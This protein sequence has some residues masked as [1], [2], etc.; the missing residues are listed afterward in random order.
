[1]YS[2]LLLQVASQLKASADPCDAPFLPEQPPTPLPPLPPPV[3]PSLTNGVAT[4]AAAKPLPTLIK[5]DF[6]QRLTHG[7][8]TGGSNQ[9]HSFMGLARDAEYTGLGYQQC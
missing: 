9:I 8:K 1:M 5:V 2:G 6:M 4:P 7:L 3:P